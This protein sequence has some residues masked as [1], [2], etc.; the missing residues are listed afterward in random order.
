MLRCSMRGSLPASSRAASVASTADGSPLYASIRSRSRPMCAPSTARMPPASASVWMR[1]RSAFA[2]ASMR[3]ASAFSPASLRAFCPRC[4][5]SCCSRRASSIWFCSSFS[6]MA[7]SL[8]TACAR[9]RNVASSASSWMRSRV[10]ASRARSTSVDGLIDAT[11]TVTSD[12]PRSSSTM[13]RRN[14]LR[15]PCGHF[16]DRAARARVAAP[17]GRTT[18]PPPAPAASGS[19]P[20]SPAAAAG[21]S[22]ATGRWRSRRARRQRR[23]GHAIGQAPLD[24]DVLEVGRP[25][26]NRQR[27]LAVVDRHLRHADANGLNQNDSPR[28][29]RFTLAPWNSNTWLEASARR[30]LNIGNLR[31][32]SHRNPPFVHLT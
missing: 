7:R 27:H 3:A 19:R 23:L 10:G 4:S 22:P 24:D 26:V 21:G 13:R 25:A 17:P 20:A 2:S 11:R 15:S 14:R 31:D 30:C 12:S 16:R 6:A 8:S 18:A 9:R 5:I 28:P 29:L 32:I 1:V